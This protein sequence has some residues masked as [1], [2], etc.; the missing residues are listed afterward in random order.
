MSPFTEK[1]SEV[2]AM[3]MIIILF[4]QTFI[5]NFIKSDKRVYEF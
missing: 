3:T 5:V 2:Y 4:M 1:L